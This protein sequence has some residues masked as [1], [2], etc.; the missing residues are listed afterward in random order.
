MGLDGHGL[1]EKADV[2]PYLGVHGTAVIMTV[3]TV[4][5]TITARMIT[6][7]PTIAVV[8]RAAVIR[9]VVIVRRPT[10]D[11]AGARADITET[12]DISC[13]TGQTDG[14]DCEA[15]NLENSFHGRQGGLEKPSLIDGLLL[16]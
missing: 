10:I 5:I 15:E 12:I 13:T 9:S 8:A 6:D 14:C 11:I 2:G 16:I 7:R 3:N 1:A 4:A